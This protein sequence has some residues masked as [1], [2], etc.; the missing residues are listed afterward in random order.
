MDRQ[1]ISDRAYLVLFRA[2]AMMGEEQNKII[3][4]KIDRAK[5]HRLVEL[6]EEF[7]DAV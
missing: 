7:A 2:I 3:E 5:A 6:K 1:E 4:T